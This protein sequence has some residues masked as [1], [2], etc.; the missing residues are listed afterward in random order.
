MLDEELQSSFSAWLRLPRLLAGEASIGWCGSTACFRFSCR[1]GL[2][3]PSARG[4]GRGQSC[5][6][7]TD[8]LP[9]CSSAMQGTL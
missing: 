6:Q 2:E 8:S 9:A 4:W 5:C 7:T 1:D 3:E